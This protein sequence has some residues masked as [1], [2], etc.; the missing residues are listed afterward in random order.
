MSTVGFRHGGGAAPASAAV[1]APERSPADDAQSALTRALCLS[2]HHRAAHDRQ[3]AG[4]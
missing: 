3:A 1:G 4:Q 2:G